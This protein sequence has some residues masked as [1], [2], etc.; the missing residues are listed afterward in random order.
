MRFGADPFWE[1]NQRGTTHSK[2]P[3]WK[4]GMP[5]SFFQLRDM[6]IH[7]KIQTVGMVVFVDSKRQRY[8]VCIDEDMPLEEWAFHEVELYQNTSAS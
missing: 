8:R 7:K 2:F 4:A 1:L 3:P 6:L 5:S